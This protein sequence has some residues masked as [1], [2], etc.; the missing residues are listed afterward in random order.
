MFMM[1]PVLLAI[2]LICA[3]TYS[4]ILNGIKAVK[5]N[6]VFILPLAAI[7]ILINILFNHNGNT[8]IGN[9]PWFGNI[10][11]ESVIAGF[12]AAGLIAVIICWFSCFNVIMSSEKIL[13][14]F[15]RI[16]PSL[17]IVL[18][19]IF[20]FI[21]QFKGQFKKT[22]NAQK[23][24]GCDI[25][26]GRLTSRIKNISKIMSVMTG[27]ALEN[28]IET[29]DSMIGR[30]YGLKGK[31]SFSIY[32]FRKEDLFLL[33]FILITSSYIIAGIIRGNIDYSFYPSVEIKYSYDIFAAYLLLC[34]LP[35]ITEIQENMR[36][37]YYQLKI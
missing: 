13:Y 8:L 16:M 31:T 27:W 2:S 5:F 37:K 35:I 4:I 25:S 28:S 26:S 20:R 10:T 9:L 1:H 3:I 36:W 32:K 24:I 34:L 30:G 19:M 12:A 17:S 33:I 29:A 6:L 15:G 14:L 7:S 23:C 22:V 11:Y 18:S 21:P